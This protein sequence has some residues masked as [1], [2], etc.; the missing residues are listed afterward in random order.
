MPNVEVE[1]LGVVEFPDGMAP[2][3]M[4]R[5]IRIALLKKNVPEKPEVPGF[6]DLLGEETSGGIKQVVEGLFSPMESFEELGTRP[7]EVV[8]GALRATPPFSVINAASRKAGL[9]T[10]EATDSPVA[11][12]GMDIATNL[13]LGALTGQVGRAGESFAR[14]KLAPRLPGA[15]VALHEIGETQ[16]RGTPKTLLPKI[17]SED[18]YTALE[19]ANVPGISLPRYRALAQKLSGSE[20]DLENFGLALPRVQRVAGKGI[21]A[22]EE[23]LPGAASQ[24]L[25]NAAGQPLVTGA[26]T[27]S[28]KDV[29]FQTLQS[30]RKRLGVLI[31]KARGTPF[32]S[33]EPELGPLKQAFKALSE[34][35]EKTP[36]SAPGYA[37]LKEANDAAKREFF[38]E[39]LEHMVA[40]GFIEAGDAGHPFKNVWKKFQKSELDDQL[41]STSVSAQ[42]ME[43]L[44]A[45]LQKLARLPKKP[46]GPGAE[47]GAGANLRRG[48]I[49]GTIGLGVAKL[50]GADPFT[51]MAA[52]SSLH[53]AFS[54]AV[55][56]LLKTEKGRKVLVTFMERTPRITPDG[57]Q[58]LTAASRALSAQGQ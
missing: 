52:G 15:A 49:G 10:L 41:F 35:L 48:G 32:G 19:Q 8:S 55:S 58:L 56:G 28:L 38:V 13:G 46:T 50:T 24:T 20:A 40:K 11:A 17:P 6:L 33:E 42:E 39:E 5:Q 12:A 44:K 7:G 21:K 18:L 57:I 25:V 47:F 4:T 27:K 22:T 51:A 23:I 29:P 26:G 1:G 9:E 43:R 37:L 54:A 16:L 53:I 36:A 31:R 2:E 34:D 45:T 3:E 30:L 14:T